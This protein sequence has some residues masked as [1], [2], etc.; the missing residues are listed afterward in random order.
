MAFI[1]QDWARVTT[2][3]A[4]VSVY[5]FT[6]ATDDKATIQ[7]ADYF[8]EGGSQPDLVQTVK[9]GDW[10]L[11]NGTD[12]G[13]ILIVATVDKVTPALTVTVLV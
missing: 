13:T 1:R 4:G 10:I 3:F 2:S 11:A 5:T 12:G 8:I 6:S 9:V 7:A